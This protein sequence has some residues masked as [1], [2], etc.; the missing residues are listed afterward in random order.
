MGL[1]VSVA[2]GGKIIPLIHL[3]VAML[4]SALM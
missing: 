3:E 1:G 4:G 2:A